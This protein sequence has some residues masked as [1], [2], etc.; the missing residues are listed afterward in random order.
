MFAT[1]QETVCTFNSQYTF[2]FMWRS[3]YKIFLSVKMFTLS[4]KVIK[5]SKIL[6]VS[7][8]RDMTD[9]VAP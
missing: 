4:D 3:D 8:P 1:L 9:H 6:A 2:D 5:E 7:W